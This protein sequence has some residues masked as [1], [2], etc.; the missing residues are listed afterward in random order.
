MI[1]EAVAPITA[2]QITDAWISDRGLECDESTKVVLRKRIG[3]TLISLRNSGV[4]RN[5]GTGA[6]G[7]KAWV[8]A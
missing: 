4:L 2:A 7:F 5:E 1:R 6:D 3:A 8:G